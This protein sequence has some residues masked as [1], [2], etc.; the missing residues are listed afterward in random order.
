MAKIEEIKQT[1]LKDVETAGGK[2]KFGFFSIPPSAT[3]GFNAFEQKKGIP[4]SL[5]SHQGL[6]RKGQN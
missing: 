3:A 6:K 5:C 4:P 2:S 1:Y